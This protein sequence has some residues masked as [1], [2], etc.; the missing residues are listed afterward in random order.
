[1]TERYTTTDIQ[2]VQNVNGPK[3]GYSKSSGISIIE[4]DGLF[5]KDLSKDGQLDKYEDWR[6]S[7]E[8]RAQDLASKMKVEQ[9]AG[10]M[11]YSSHQ[12]VPAH[13]KGWFA[14]TYN[15][16]S[17]EESGMKPWELTDE[18]IKFLKEDYV[19]HI[20]ITT[21]ESPLVAAKWN[22]N[23]QALSETAE[24]GIPANNSTDPR[25]SSDSNTEFN[26]GAGGQISMWPETLG[27]AATFNPAITKRFGEIGA[28]EYRALGI[29]TALSPQIDIA[30]DPRWFRFSGTFGED[31]KLT[32]DMA[33]AYVD[34]FQT[35]SSEQEIEKGWGYDSVNAM[36]KHWP[37]G[38][39]GEAGRDAHYGA[40][41][42]AVYPGNNFAEH[43]LPFTEGA[44]KLEGATST[45]AAV[46]PY[47]TIS[48]D[49]DTVNGDNVGNAYNRYLIKDL[50]RQQY[51]YDG[52]ICTDW[53]ITADEV[54][55]KDS[56]IGGKSWG[57]EEL[58]VA[59]R[60]YKLILAGVDQF[61]GNNDVKPVLEAY[62]LGVAE[63][64]ETFMRQRF[65]Q[66]AVRLLLNIFRTGL[67][68]NPYLIAEESSE[69]VGDAT[70]IQEGFDAQLKSIVMLK[71]K[72]NVLPVMK[73]SKLYIPTRYLES[74]KDWFGMHIPA[75]EEFPMNREIVEKYFELTDRPEEA[76]LALVCITNPQSGMGYSQE[77]VDNGGNGY[78]PISLQYAPYTATHARET[79]IAGDP[80][81]SDV[82]N[83]SY[84]GKTVVPRN[85]KDL[86]L[87]LQTKELMK[88]KPVIVSLLMMNPT[89]V[90]EFEQAADA[91]LVNFGVQDQAIM[92]VIA[93]HE[94]S[95]LLPFQLPANMK[96]VEEQLEDV[97]HDM[98]CY[99]DSEGNTYDFAFGLNWSGAIND[100][101]VAK[102]GK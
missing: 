42:Y 44:F 67:F 70:F 79:S 16:K 20:L 36:V 54:E 99:I 76:D 9:I 50:L 86:D 82:L 12:S 43:L 39:S 49:Q 101:R 17:F 11:L 56:F 84:K 96:T 78:I 88:G 15:G 92:E 55:Q 91:I 73:K 33:R 26:A 89:I 77:D 25:H 68:E 6:L 8:E 69:I 22:N 94:P 29:T 34:G 18:Q 46:M 57:V 37:G 102:Y 35:S 24:L 58:T 51:G 98:E 32:T 95:G 38:G 52:V 72:G 65:E 90:A 80:R 19:R 53:G 14:G 75:K 93:G 71:N 47:Y 100:Q 74:G 59:E 87:V 3:L 61:G 85:M 7:A 64:G 21:V 13:S 28:M 1:M 45:A 10:L 97:P 83:R 62:Q 66:S 30:T 31:T 48:L 63:F 2:Y 4:Q 81:S 41:K 40:G 23:I 27:L 60:H 5:F